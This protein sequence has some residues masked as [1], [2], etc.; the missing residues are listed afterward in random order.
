MKL[1]NRSHIE[2]GF[3]IGVQRK[4]KKP[5][6]TLCLTSKTLRDRPDNYQ[7]RKSGLYRGAISVSLKKFALTVV[8][9]AIHLYAFMHFKPHFLAHRPPSSFLQD[10]PP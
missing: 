1:K 3:F 7:K 5:L 8:I 6:V 10:K 9:T 2:S 4:H